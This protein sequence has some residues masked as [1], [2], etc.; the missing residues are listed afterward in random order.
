MHAPALVTSYTA[1][2]RR[3]VD[4]VRDLPRFTLADGHVPDAGTR[5]VMMKIVN[6]LWAIFLGCR[7]HGGTM[8][9]RSRGSEA[10]MVAL[11]FMKIFGHLDVDYPHTRCNF[12]RILISGLAA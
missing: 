7:G 12:D 1:K 10:K 8:S 9:S 5:A 3:K 11:V 2:K 4:V 6:T